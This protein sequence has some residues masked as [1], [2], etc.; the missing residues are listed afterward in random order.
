MVVGPN[1]GVGRELLRRLALAGPGW[2]GF[3]HATP[4]SLAHDLAAPSLAADGLAGVDEIERRAIVDEALDAA[5]DP[6]HSM[7]ELA[8][9]VGFRDAVANAV[10]ALRLAGLRPDDVAGAGLEDADKARF[11]ARVLEG[12]QRGL[13]ERGR[14]DA[15]DVFRRAVAVVEEGG[16]AGDGAAGSDAAGTRAGSDG[17]AAPRILLMAELPDRGLAGRF[18][19]ALADRAAAETLPAEIGA[20]PT[21][22]LFA[23]G[24][25]ADEV[26]ETLRRV[27]ASGRR[28]DEV[29]IV[30]TDP[31]VYGSALD[32]LAT[33]LGIP[34]TYAVGLPVE[35]TRQ[36]RAVAA[37]LEWIQSDFPSE[38]VRR[39][40]ETGDLRPAGAGEEDGVPSGDRLA[41]RLREL[42]IGWGRARY[43]KAIGH[44]LDWLE[45][46]PAEP[47]GDDWRTAEE[48]AEK[49]AR[50]LAE[51]RA[52]K[53]LL[54]A[55]LDA[56]APVPDRVG[57]GGGPTSSA[58]IARGVM[59]FLAHVPTPTPVE[60]EARRRL[61]ERLEAVDQKLFRP[62]G[63][64]AAVTILRGHLDLRVPSPGAEGPLPWSSA[65]G[66]LHLSDLD[67]GGWTGRPLTFVVGLDAERFPGAGIQ[68][69][70][71]LDE[72]RLRLDAD[73]L[74][75]STDRLAEKRDAL[76]ALRARVGGSLTLSC[77][78][79]SALEGRAVAPAADLLQAF[80][81]RERDPARNY[82]DLSDA[83]AP[84]AC[85]VPRG[86]GR[87]DAADVW[88]AALSSD[89][90]LKSGV[91]Q[92]LEA[93]PRLAAGLAA[94][95]ARQGPG[96]TAWDGR[97]EP[98][99]DALDP[100]RSGRL[101]S[102]SQLERLAGC[103]LSH[104]YRKVLY[105]R[106]P[107]D[108]ELD[109][110][111]WLEARHRGSLLH[112]VYE[113]ALRRARE[114]AVGHDEAGFEEVALEVL[115]EQLDR[116]RGKVPVPS[117]VV[118]RH[119]AE[120]LRRD[121]GSFVRHVRQHGVSWVDLEKVFGY[122]HAAPPPVE[123][124]LDGGTLKVCGRIDRIDRT[125]DG[126]VV[127]DYKTGG[128]WGYGAKEGT[129]NGGRHL[130]HL[131]YTR[132]AERLYGEPVERMEY[133][134][135]SVR[136]QNEVRRYEAAWLREGEAVLDAILD[137]VATGRFVPS[138]D[139]S[140][141]KYCDYKAICRVEVGDWNDIDSP[142][143]EWAKTRWEELGEY[144]RLRW[145]RALG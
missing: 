83:L 128:T 90:G 4:A 33:R 139:E 141:C 12:Y 32:A 84:I 118:F 87:L 37:Y 15:A 39:M 136:G 126:L 123:I 85:P 8:D 61:V 67:H 1:R 2:V 18:L 145:L 75:T 53:S 77:S 137:H 68:D 71:L 92:V 119:E 99:P 79:W 36:G 11:L 114:R 115:S 74:P 51:L 10:E 132:V 103:P 5:L 81:L 130:Q 100:R 19:R 97:I 66:A 6:G 72:D 40:L 140:D 47:A 41:R 45:A 82:D 94:R 89:D 16:L 48:I 57:R 56:T 116:Y 14:V 108:P 65:G 43:L 129:W 110:G 78:Q 22:D 55:V 73:A 46:A 80:R 104:L 133:H 31:T 138:A 7:A 28:W 30:A 34:V 111:R 86:A 113:H 91:A 107:D 127:I 142:P 29:E 98:R 62:T 106:K 58:E 13:A 101:V 112:D 125:D 76:D 121:V 131:L 96:F 63:F 20:T 26:R 134:F 95:E 88:L 9:G 24:G 35:R 122:G 143:V 70:I 21:I 69:P 42:R 60:K 59:A 105:L 49:R 102:N 17:A 52:L 64:G 117:E 144:E 44:R 3:D 27:I 50:E 54:T 38:V 124:E 109:P 23:A 135:P 93:H 120:A 25:P